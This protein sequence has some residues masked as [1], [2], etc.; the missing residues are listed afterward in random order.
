[1]FYRYYSEIF[2]DCIINSADVWQRST[3]TVSA[4]AC[5]DTSDGPVKEIAPVTE[6]E[7]APVPSSL[8]FG[9]LNLFSDGVV[10][11]CSLKKYV[12]ISYS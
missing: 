8:V 7:P 12:L 4:D 11:L 5:E 1:M 2:M 6:K 3:C 10:S 9:Y